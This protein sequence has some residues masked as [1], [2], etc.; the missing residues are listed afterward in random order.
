MI[1]KA[2]ENDLKKINNLGIIFNQNFINTY[3]VKDY[4]KNSNYIILVNEDEEVN[5]FMIIYKNLDYYELEAII[6]SPDCRK[7]GIANNLLTHFINIYLKSNDILLL[8]VAINNVA[9]INLY[10][11]FQ[12]EII[13]IRKKYYQNI[14]AYVMKKVI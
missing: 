4:L 10:K 8:E 11:K 3:N 1:R 9:A 2:V 13:N 5:A 14:D 12:F 6:V 7:K